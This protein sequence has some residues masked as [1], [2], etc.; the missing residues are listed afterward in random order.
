MLQSSQV[1]AYEEY[2][3]DEQKAEKEYNEILEKT[4]H[5]SPRHQ[6]KMG[7]LIHDVKCDE[8][9][10]L[11]MRHSNGLPA[12]VKSISVDELISRGWALDKQETMKV[13]EMELNAKE[14]II[15]DREEILNERQESLQKQ[16]NITNEP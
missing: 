9:L 1:Y 15:H 13:L 12:C 7:V 14:K 16:E 5:Y 10:E 3:E 4:S 2:E 11:I 8:G 6:I